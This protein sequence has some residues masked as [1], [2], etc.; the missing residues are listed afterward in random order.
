MPNKSKLSDAQWVKV[1]QWESSGIPR[2]EMVRRLAA[3]DGV[4]ITRGGLAKAIG[5]R[6]YE[7]RPAPESKSYK[8]AITDDEKDRLREVAARLGVR[9]FGA[10][11][12]VPG[13]IPAMLRG[14]AAGELVVSS[15]D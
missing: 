14:I 10:A 6:S 2:T 11:H 4:H 9:H 13:S 7:K 3:E 5:Q 8:I 15:R 1:E 12:D